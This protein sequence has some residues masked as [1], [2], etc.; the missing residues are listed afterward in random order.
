MSVGDRVDD[1]EPKANAVPVARAIGAVS[2]KWPQQP[3]DLTGR[4]D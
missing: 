4:D 2:L 1:R 3:I